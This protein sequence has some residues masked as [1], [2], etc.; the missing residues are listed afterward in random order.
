MKLRKDARVE[1]VHPLYRGEGIMADQEKQKKTTEKKPTEKSAKAKAA[2]DPEAQAAEAAP[3]PAAA[4]K[5]TAPKRPKGYGR[6]LPKNKHR[7]P[8]RQKKAQKKAAARS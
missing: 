3:A 2:K 8:R 6:L 4:P 1:E 7:L 5:V